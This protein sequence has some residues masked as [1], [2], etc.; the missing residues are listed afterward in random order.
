PR[1]LVSAPAWRLFDS[2]G[3]VDYRLCLSASAIAPVSAVAPNRGASLA[4]VAGMLRPRMRRCAVATGDRVGIPMG[5]GKPVSA[6]IPAS[7]IG[8]GYTNDTPTPCGAN[9]VYAGAAGGKPEDRAALDDPMAAEVH[10]AVLVRPTRVYSNPASPTGR[11]RPSPVISRY[12]AGRSVRAQYGV[13]SPRV[14]PP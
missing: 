4:T 12:Q 1:S 7:R 14:M 8:P 6:H 5:A 3:L 10:T 2:S 11:S 9:Q 13:T